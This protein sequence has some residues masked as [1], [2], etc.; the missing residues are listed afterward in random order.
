MRFRTAD[1]QE[2]DGIPVTPGVLLKEDHWSSDGSVWVVEPGGWRRLLRWEEF[3]SLFPSPNDSTREANSKREA[4]IVHDDLGTIKILPNSP[5][6]MVSSAS[7]DERKPPAQDLSGIPDNKQAPIQLI[8]AIYASQSGPAPSAAVLG[9]MAPHDLYAMLRNLEDRRPPGFGF[10]NPFAEPDTPVSIPA[11]P[12]PPSPAPNPSPAST[13]LRGAVFIAS[14]ELREWSTRHSP[15]GVLHMREWFDEKCRNASGPMFEI[16]VDLEDDYLVGDR[17]SRLLE[18]C[19]T[20][21]KRAHIWV[22]GDTE[23]WQDGKPRADWNRIWNHMDGL[24]STLRGFDCY[25]LGLGFDLWEWVPGARHRDFT[26]FHRWIRAMREELPG[27]MIGGRPQAPNSRNNPDESWETLDRW[28]HPCTYYSVEYGKPTPGELDKLAE[29]AASQNKIAFSEN[30]D[31][32][33]NEPYYT[34]TPEELSR[35]IREYR[36]RGIACIV[37][38]WEFKR[39]RGRRS[40]PLPHGIYEAIDVPI[41]TDT[42]RLDW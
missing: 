36:K 11:V 2:H 23:H 38:N 8:Q 31:R 13:S 15:T 3:L 16:G 25:S 4:F 41:P 29:Q 12:S 7:N 24:V 22:Q 32:L 33:F 35:V 20:R 9:N 27:A 26:E 14:P 37:A 1:G 19:Q 30:R 10:S 6:A 17:L 21:K 28:N 39:E 18:E 34:Y 40:G 42:A 5:P